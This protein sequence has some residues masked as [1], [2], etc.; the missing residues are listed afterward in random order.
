M[1]SDEKDNWSAEKYN[2]SAFFVYSDAYTQPI[3]DL[4][5]LKQGERVIDIGC[6]TGEL[7]VRLQNFLGDD[8]I[9]VGVD[10]SEDMLKRARENGLKNSFCCDA[11]NLIL[12]ENFNHL[13]GTFDAVFTNAT[14]HWCKRD[15][16]A[17]VRAARK[18]LRPGGRFVGEFGGYMNCTGVRSAMHQ[19]LLKRGLDPIPLDPWYFPRAQEYAKVLESQGFEVQHASLHPRITPLPGHLNDW[20]YTFARNSALASMNDEEARQ[21]IQE[22]SDI[23][24]V[25]MKDESGG[26][27]IMYVRL[28]FVAIRPE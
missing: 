6:G 18:L 2:K 4:L 7:S 23:C 10:A 19:V 24:E 11:Q 8:G 27:G 17:V 13:T 21:M 9:L 20:L 12:P 28:R 14:L 5:K 1:S 22:I 15:P 16:A 3:L 25:D 26:W